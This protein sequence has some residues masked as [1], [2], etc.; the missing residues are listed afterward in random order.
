M[1][2][3]NFNPGAITGPGERRPTTRRPRGRS[4]AA[5][6]STARVPELAFKMDVQVALDGEGPPPAPPMTL[7]GAPGTPRPLDPEAGA[8][9]A[10]PVRAWVGFALAFAF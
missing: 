4:S 6:S 5:A 10:R 8:G 2:A 3:Y 7:A 9:G 1:S